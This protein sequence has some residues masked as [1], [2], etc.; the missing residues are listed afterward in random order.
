MVCGTPT[1]EHRFSLQ[2][3]TD[4]TLSTADPTASPVSARGA[5]GIVNAFSR[6]SP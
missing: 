3:G 1:G 6:S 5:A 2:R 4:F